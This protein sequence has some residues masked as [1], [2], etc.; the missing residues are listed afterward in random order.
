MI[1]GDGMETP[2]QTTRVPIGNVTILLGSKSD[3][4]VAESITKTL[5]NIGVGYQVR[6]R[7]AHR[8][9]ERLREFLRG[10]MAEVTDVFIGV[11]GVAA[12][13]PGAIASERRTALVIGVPVP[14]AQGDDSIPLNSMLYMPPGVP[15]LVVGGP[16]APKNA[17][18]AAAQAI[19]LRY[20]EMTDRLTDFVER[21]RAKSADGAQEVEKKLETA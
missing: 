1:I 11:A 15:V 16:G 19:A 18:I 7:S 4:K 14:D 6:I 17:A 2:Q 21:D 13:L 3:E 5:R 20:P 12:A 8:D 9:P 10:E